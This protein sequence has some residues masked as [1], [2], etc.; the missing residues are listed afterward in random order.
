MLLYKKTKTILYNFQILHTD[1]WGKIQLKKTR[2]EK[3]PGSN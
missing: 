1:V 2:K 3:K